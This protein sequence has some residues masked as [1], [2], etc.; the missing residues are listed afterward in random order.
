M[1]ICVAL[2]ALIFLSC[3]VRKLASNKGGENPGDFPIEGDLPPAQSYL[4]NCQGP[5]L[6]TVVDVSLVHTT[7]HVRED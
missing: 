2:P 5:L 3:D 4:F 1:C 7:N 6:D